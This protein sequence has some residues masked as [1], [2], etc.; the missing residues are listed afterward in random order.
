MPLQ[1]GARVPRRITN[2][3]ARVSE[4]PHT[5]LRHT[6]YGRSTDLRRT[7]KKAV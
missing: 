2:S 1:G 3:A 6:P 4:K 5:W 7:I